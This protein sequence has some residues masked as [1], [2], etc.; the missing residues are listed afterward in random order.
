MLVKYRTFIKMNKSTSKS[1][2]TA[3]LKWVKVSTGVYKI[4]FKYAVRKMTDGT[5]IYR[6]FTNKTKAITFYNSL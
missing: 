1:K 3:S 4:G 5:R 6:S 2:R